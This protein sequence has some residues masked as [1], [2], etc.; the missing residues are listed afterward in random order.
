MKRLNRKVKTKY[1]VS[2]AHN[3]FSR[4]TKAKKTKFTKTSATTT[5]T[6]TTIRPKPKR[7]R[8]KRKTTNH[9]VM[10]FSIWATTSLISSSFLCGIASTATA[11][12]TITAT[13]GRGNSNLRG[14]FTTVTASA[15]T[16][17]TTADDAPASGSGNTRKLTTSSLN[18]PTNPSTWNVDMWKR[19]KYVD[20]V[21]PFL[22]LEPTH[23]RQKLI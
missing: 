17:A 11:T 4:V 15:T 23:I 22:L 6:A 19:V 12:A 1:P 5:A 16:T 20:S 8:R 7:N 10:K 9:K 18:D 14:A 21:S 2:F 3:F 13:N